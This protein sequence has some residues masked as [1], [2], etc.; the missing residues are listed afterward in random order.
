MSDS[1]LQMHA[2]NSCNSLNSNINNNLNSNPSSASLVKS[3][4]T[5]QLVSDSPITDPGQ[6]LKVSF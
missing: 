1:G 4:Q 2:I 3:H 5:M 6:M